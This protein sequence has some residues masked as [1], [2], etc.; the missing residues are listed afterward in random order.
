MSSVVYFD[1]T[2]R[3]FNQTTNSI[4]YVKVLMGQS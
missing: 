4:Q 3:L 2:T 1:D